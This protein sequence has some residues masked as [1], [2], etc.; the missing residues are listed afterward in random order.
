MS[1][2]AVTKRVRGVRASKAAA[3]SMP[4]ELLERLNETARQRGVKKSHV[5]VAALQAYLTANTAVIVDTGF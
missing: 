5:V 1:D 2:V 3:F 4:K